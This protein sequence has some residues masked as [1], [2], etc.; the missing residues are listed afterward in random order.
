MCSW[1]DLLHN[2]AE[3]WRKNMKVLHVNTYDWVGIKLESSHMSVSGMEV[4]LDHRHRVVN[5]KLHLGYC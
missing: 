4:R 1:E 5:T 3:T 2:L